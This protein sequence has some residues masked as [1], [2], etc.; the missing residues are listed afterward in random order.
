M[1]SVSEVLV[2]IS[3]EERIRLSERLSE[4]ERSQFLKLLN[5]F[6]PSELEDLRALV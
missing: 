1:F 6:T 3:I 5:Y 4:E 2:E